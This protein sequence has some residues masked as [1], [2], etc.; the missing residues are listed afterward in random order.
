MGVMNQEKFLTN[1]NYGVG[2]DFGIEGRPASWAGS[3][4]SAHRF[5]DD[6]DDSTKIPI[7]ATGPM[8]T[9]ITGTSHDEKFIAISSGLAVVVFDLETQK[10]SL[11]SKDSRH[12]API[13]ISLRYT[14]SLEAIPW[15]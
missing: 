8:S 5:W 12:A 14:A 4:K 3:E 7:D 11:S 1:Y 15:L 9:S 10:V 13:S 6:E 2:Q